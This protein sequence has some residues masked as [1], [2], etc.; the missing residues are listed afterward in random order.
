MGKTV[1]A[2]YDAKQQALWLLEPLEGVGDGQPKRSMSRFRPAE[3][4]SLTTDHGFDLNV[5]Q[6]R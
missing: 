2:H 6:W 4:H 3:G 5:I 1:K